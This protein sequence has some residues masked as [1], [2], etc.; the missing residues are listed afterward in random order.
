MILSKI[1]NV[2][3]SCKSYSTEELNRAVQQLS[4][5]P[6]TPTNHHQ[7]SNTS[8]SPTITNF[9][10]FFTNINGNASNF[11]SL[12]I[13][14][15]RIKHKFSVIGLAETNTDEPLHSLYHIPGYNSFYQSTIE[16]KCKGTGVA[17]YISNNLNA[18]IIENLGYCTPDIESLFVRISDPTNEHLTLI[19]GVIYRPPNGDFGKFNEEYVHICSQLPNSGIRIMGDFNVDLLKLNNISSGS[20]NHL[21][22]EESFMN[23]G[24]SPVISTPTHTR[25]NCNPSCID[26]IF[27]TDI[28]EV[29]ISGTLKDQVGDHLPVFEFTN[30]KINDDCKNQE[31]KIHYDFCNKN[32][33]KFISTIEN[34][35]SE[36]NYVT[37][38][39]SDFTKVFGEALDTACKL[40]KPKVSKRTPLQNPWITD[41][42]ISAIEKKHELKNNWVDTITTQFPLGDRAVYEIYKSYRTVLKCVINS[43]K[44]SYR[45]S[46]VMDN[47]HDRRKTWQIINEFRG[48]QIRP[49]KP[50]FV[51][52]NK[53]ITDRRII[54]NKFNE[55]FNSI[56]SKL[57]QSISDCNLSACSL[58]SFEDFLMPSSSRSIYLEDCTPQELMEIISTLDNNKSSDIPIKIIKKSAHIICPVISSYFNI[59]MSEGYFP[60]VLKVGKIT[61]IYK[62][63]NVEDMSNYRPVST[64]PI[65]GKIFEKV[66]Y[67]RLYKFALSQ[68]L[69]NKNQF[70]FRKSHSTSHAV[71]FSVKIIEE[72]LA[73]KKN[74]HVL[75]IFID[76]SKAFDT[77]DHYILLN[78]LDKYGIRGNTNMLIKSYLSNRTQYTKT[79]ECKSEPLIVEYGVPQGSVLGPLLFLLYIN[80]I[81]NCSDLGTFVLFAD[82]T[83]IF[84]QGKSAEDALKKGNNLLRSL[85]NYMILN[86]LHINMTKCCYVHFKPKTSPPSDTQN[87]LSIDSFPIKKTASAKFLGVVID[88]KRSWEPHINALRRK[89]NYASATLC[90]IRDSIPETLHKDLYHTL[91][92]SHMSYCISVWGEASPTLVNKIFTAQKHCLRVLF[93]DKASYLDKFET[94]ARVRPFSSKAPDQTIFELEHSKPIFKSQQILTVQ[95]LYSYH[96]YMETIKIL[97]FRY[98]LSL[99]EQYNIS[100]RK[101]MLLITSQPSANFISR[102]TRLWNIIT[103]KL[104][105]LDYSVKINQVKSNLKRGILSLQHANDDIQWID[106]SFNIEKFPTVLPNY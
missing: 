100:N 82:D 40:E 85:K 80:D 76:L 18:E 44:N 90:R 54:A 28:D 98:P 45:C 103:P 8:S 13:E 105:L 84:V 92:E 1:S 35:F 4:R 12:L 17:I 29:L 89:L 74:K 62:K 78:K 86:K 52:D 61:P 23:A 30:L 50:S 48:K 33:N 81:S 11:D 2:L 10:S 71:N 20:S 65:F 94:C 34:E 37:N 21:K 15:K 53:K 60:D 24:L 106:D 42:I 56:A 104:K 72:S 36:W 99:Y 14:L 93:G 7:T 66:I 83:N 57:N 55:Y 5:S 68:N 38:K 102:S 97:K 87:V 43:A 16:G 59:H 88:E 25:L 32:L 67:S 69:L 6:N 75:G 58:K 95:N 46:K 19:S 27:T 101:E 51:I 26:N 47:I 39:F 31:N 9:S 96:T 73:L 3:S 70:G 49:M 79:L 91:F 22:F 63:G 64:L 77:I 41:G